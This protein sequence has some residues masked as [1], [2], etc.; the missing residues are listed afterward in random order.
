ME[1]G[2]CRR[3]PLHHAVE[4]SLI[5][6]HPTPR[7]EQIIGRP[8]RCFERGDFHASTFLPT[9]RVVLVRYGQQSIAIGYSS[10]EVD[11]VDALQS[12]GFSVPW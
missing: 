9:C 12:P 2:S 7:L 4:S 3:T 5:C 6:R 10:N 11:A 8:L 1:V